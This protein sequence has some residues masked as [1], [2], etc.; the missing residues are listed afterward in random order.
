LTVVGSVQ[1]RR[2]RFGARL[3][4]ATG[5]PYT[6]VV[7]ASYS[8]ELGRYLP[9]LGAPYGVRYPDVT[10]VDLRLERAFKTKR[11][12]LAAFIDFGNVFR[13]AS[14]ARYQYNADFSEKTPLTEYVPLPSL[15]IRGEI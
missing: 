2:W 13:Q 6:D 5:L 7:G 10:R 8:D 4:Y 9:L 3:S 11:V 12:E 15:G 1:T 14:V